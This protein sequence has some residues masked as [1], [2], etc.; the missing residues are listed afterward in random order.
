[1]HGEPQLSLAVGDGGASLVDGADT[2]GDLDQ[3]REG[4]VERRSRNIAASTPWEVR[5]WLRCECY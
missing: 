5:A 1:M 4:W 3:V 2:V